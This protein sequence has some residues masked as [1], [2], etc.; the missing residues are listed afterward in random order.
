MIARSSPGAKF[1]SRFIPIFPGVGS[2]FS[3]PGTDRT[4]RHE[5]LPD[6]PLRVFG[7]MKE[8]PEN[9]R[10]QTGPSYLAWIGKGRFFGCLE[11]SECALDLIV[12]STDQLSYAQACF[13]P[14]FFLF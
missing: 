11:L 10:G 8:Q 5:Q 12:E 3:T 4:D 9:I 13:G 7:G 6:M 14:G 2:S 1:G